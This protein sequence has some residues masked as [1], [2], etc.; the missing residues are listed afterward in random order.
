MSP[1]WSLFA[2]CHAIHPGLSRTVVGKRLKCGS[3]YHGE[4]LMMSSSG[5]ASKLDQLE[6]RLGAN[7]TAIRAAREA[8]RAKRQ[9]L[10]EC[11]ITHDSPDTS[12]VVFGSVAR[13]EV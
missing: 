2:R 7:W 9:K 3:S 12:L 11:F 5:T 13:E 4:T 6:A 10:A 1:H 8:T